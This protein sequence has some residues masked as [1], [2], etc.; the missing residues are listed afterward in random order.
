MFYFIIPKKRVPLRSVS[1][2]SEYFSL[3]LQVVYNPNTRA[4]AIMWQLEP[5]RQEAVG[6]LDVYAKVHDNHLFL[7]AF[8]LEFEY[9]IAQYISLEEVIHH[10]LTSIYA[11]IGEFTIKDLY[12]QRDISVEN[13]EDLEQ[14]VA[15][16][17][18]SRTA[19]FTQENALLN[20]IA[21]DTDIDSVLSKIT[22]LP[23]QFRIFAYSAYIAQLKRVNQN[24]QERVAKIIRPAL[25]IL[26]SL[27]DSHLKALLTFK[28]I[29]Y[30]K[31]FSSSYIDLL[32]L[33]TILVDIA[34]FFSELPV[35]HE[36]SQLLL[37]D[38]ALYLIN[39]PDPASSEQILV[40]LLELF[41]KEKSR[42][43]LYPEVK[44]IRKFSKTGSYTRG[45]E[46]FVTLNASEPRASLRSEY[47]KA[48]LAHNL[49]TEFSQQV[50]LQNYYQKLSWQNKL[51]YYFHAQKLKNKTVKK[52]PL[53]QLVVI[54]AGIIGLAS[55]TMPLAYGIFVSQ[56]NTVISEVLTP[57]FALGYFFISILLTGM[58]WY[59]G[60]AIKSLFTLAQRSGLPQMIRYLALVVLAGISVWLAATALFVLFITQFLSISGDTLWGIHNDRFING[61]MSIPLDSIKKITIDIPTCDGEPCT[62]PHV[63]FV[64]E[65]TDG[66]VPKIMFITDTIQGN[67]KER[68][69]QIISQLNE[70]TPGGITYET[71]EAKILIAETCGE[72]EAK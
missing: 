47:E 15:V 20:S 30:Y 5:K 56:S 69:C 29:L 35:S 52:D 41:K 8:S 21:N 13:S 2:P 50:L 38:L 14:A 1:V 43:L 32:P 68:A 26:L 55:Y 22:E 58:L 72:A 7:D 53:A 4:F 33:H 31:S 66:T 62:T 60:I 25:D 64:V 70:H 67:T 44:T 27:E 45:F 48:F 42:F 65:G 12:L 17:V 10:T 37:A 57:S 6:F 49:V 19:S 54:V 36:I 59:T 18:E 51:K 23:E 71:E 16:L 40:E 39:S 24:T 28:L 46:T 34:P 63:D 9:K 11:K 61:Y 3:P